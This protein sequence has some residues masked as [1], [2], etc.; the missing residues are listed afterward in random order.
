MM[1]QD[2]A[3]TSHSELRPEFLLRCRGKME[4]EKRYDVFRSMGT[5][6][7]LTAKFASSCDK[8]LSDQ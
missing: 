6:A 5:E 1:Y 4:T 2:S 8:I 7:E 3:R